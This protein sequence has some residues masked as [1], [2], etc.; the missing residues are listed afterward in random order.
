MGTKCTSLLVDLFLYS[1]S[2]YKTLSKQNTQTKAFNHAFR[3]IDDVLPI[4]NP[5]FGNWILEIKEATETASPVF[6]S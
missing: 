4:N 2:F 6:V 3:Y 5:N 1:Y